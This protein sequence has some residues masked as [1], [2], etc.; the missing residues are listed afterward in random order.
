[1]TP[2]APTQAVGALVPASATDRKASMLATTRTF[3]AY[4]TSPSLR[5][6]VD[7]CSSVT[8]EIAEQLGVDVIEFPFVMA[9]GDHRADQWESIT[10][11]QFYGRMR[12]GER[13]L[14]SAI[15]TGEFLDLFEACAREGVPTIY[16]SLTA[17]LS[18]SVRD[19]EQ[20]AADVSAKHPGFKIAALDNRMPSLT[21]L[22][23]AREVCHLRDG[24]S[25]FEE[26]V[27]FVRRAPDRVHGYFTL[28]SL[29]WL[30]AG[31]R[32][33]KAAASLSALLDM[34]A[35]LTY[36]L[37][38]ALTLTGVSR[39]R[40]KALKGLVAKL[41][42]N[43]VGGPGLPIGIADADCP[44][45]ADALERQVRAWFEAKGTPCPEIMRLTIDATIGSH[46]GPGMVALAF[47]GI[48]RSA[49]SWNNGKR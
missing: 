9:D 27:D 48:D 31:G 6:I 42:G 38:G 15:P 39:G 16:L 2:A 41:D 30:A 8:T 44:E 1:M 24:G 34:K 10:P 12:A 36:D 5:V 7:S 28:D 21:A 17:G 23:L 3:R 25:S 32:I 33:P 20:A 13:A 14:T 46:V 26:V 29:R 22:M 47:W 19:A 49:G 35:N 45:D 4:S 11:A 37:D 43:Y 18:S 40:K